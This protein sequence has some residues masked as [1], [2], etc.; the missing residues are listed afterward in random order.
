M[1]GNRQPVGTS[2]NNGY[3]RKLVHNIPWKDY[4]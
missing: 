4:Y 1:R 3:F 2:T